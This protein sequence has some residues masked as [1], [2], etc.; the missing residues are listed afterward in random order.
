MVI[1]VFAFPLLW[2]CWKVVRLIP[3]GKR[4]AMLTVYLR[5]LRSPSMAFDPPPQATPDIAALYS[6]SEPRRTV[7]IEVWHEGPQLVTEARAIT[8]Q[9]DIAYGVSL[10][11]DGSAAVMRDSDG[12][13][14]SLRV[15]R[16]DGT[17][18][19]VANEP[20]GLILH[21]DIDH[22]T[23][24][25]WHADPAQR[26]AEIR[27]WSPQAGTQSLASLEY[28]LEAYAD[29]PG[30][31]LVHA[32]GTVVGCLHTGGRGT[33]VAARMGQPM[34]T[35]GQSNY[36]TVRRDVAAEWRG[37]PRVSVSLIGPETDRADQLTSLDLSQ[38]PPA[39]TAVR[40]GRM[41]PGATMAGGE[42]VVQWR[43]SGLL[44]LPGG[45]SVPMGGKSYVAV[46]PQSDGEFAGL[47]LFENASRGSV[48]ANWA[49]LLHLPSGARQ[50]LGRHAHGPLH[51]RG[52][53]VM[54]SE[55]MARPAK[56]GSVE[57]PPVLTW[58]GRLRRPVV[59]HGETTGAEPP[60]TD[61]PGG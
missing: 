54:W 1:A 9:T 6:P 24:V 21:A 20:T 19:D 14:Y 29:E 32:G 31:W 49:V 16:R 41:V 35:I 2:K 52:E 36:V 30:G 12:G 22:G 45:L 3:P 13:G 55:A 57:Q 60:R 47:N 59:A 53:Y 23:C 11:V 50:T 28:E 37:E 44:E 10:D 25:W 61:Q 34:V 51:I 5:H 18:F 17:S 58:V 40:R 4:V 43:Y 42:P 39:V 8:D 38:F 27:V 46:D 15:V 56:P 48:A 33:I 7:P 26:R